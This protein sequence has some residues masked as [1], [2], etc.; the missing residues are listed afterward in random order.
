MFNKS[1]N[2]ERETQFK[3]RHVKWETRHDTWNMWHETC[4]MWHT[5]CDTRP[6]TKHVACDICDMRDVK[7]ERWPGNWE[8][9]HD[10]R[11]TTN[12]TW[13]IQDKPW[14]LRYE[15]CQ[16]RHATWNMTHKTRYTIHPKW[17]MI[18][19]AW[20]IQACKLTTDKWRMTDDTWTNQIWWSRERYPREQ[21]YVFTVGF[22]CLSLNTAW[23]SYSTGWKRSSSGQRF[24]ASEQGC[25]PW[26]RQCN[27]MFVWGLISATYLYLYLY[28]CMSIL[29]Q[30][31]RS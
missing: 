26:C 18:P 23:R 12:Q 5:Q 20:Y 21:I 9:I 14:K 10:T 15:T 30:G 11:Y 3:M 28:L 16:M 4:G 17:N 25:R 7:R 31:L 13:H 22:I 2:E 24:L 29:G 1:A 19:Q 8:A 27:W 6:A